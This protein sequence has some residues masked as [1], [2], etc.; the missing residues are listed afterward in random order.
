M[1]C[2]QGDWSNLVDAKI[3]GRVAA[4]MGADAR[5]PYSPLYARAVST[6]RPW[7]VTALFAEH[8]GTQQPLEVD[9]SLERGIRTTAGSH[10][11]LAEPIAVED[12]PSAA[13]ES[14]EPV[15]QLGESSDQKVVDPPR[16]RAFST[17]WEFAIA[18][19]RSDPAALALAGDGATSDIPIDGAEL[20]RL[21]GMMWFR[22]VLGRF[23]PDWRERILNVLL[24]SA[25]V[26]DH[27]FK[28]GWQTVHLRELSYEELQE[29]G[30]T[31]LVPDRIRPDLDF[32]ITVGRFWGADAVKRFRFVEAP[33]RHEPSMMENLLQKFP[34]LMPAGRGTTYADRARAFWPLPVDY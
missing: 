12:A 14:P 16:V 24:D 18:I 13:A 4:A 15:E 2:I 26:T 6:P 3:K 27:A 22:T 29:I 19:N 28:R 8:T 1:I 25:T 20:R 5:S 33:E 9:W 23:S 7:G 34:G 17:F 31:T 21:L 30:S 11:S 10:R 32:L